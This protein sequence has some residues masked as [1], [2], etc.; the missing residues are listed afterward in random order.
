MTE[1]GYDVTA[2]WHEL[3]DGLRDIDVGFLTGPKAVA[4]EVG[5]ADGYRT[6]L[7]ALGV[8]LDTYLFADPSRPLLVDVASPLKRDRRWGGDN[9]DSWYSFTPVDPRRHYRV[10]GQRGD[11]TYFSF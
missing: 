5:A 8:A 3:L 4:D 1:P 7:T 9:T 6:A 10:S 11:S 2:A